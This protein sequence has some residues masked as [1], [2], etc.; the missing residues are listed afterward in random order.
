MLGIPRQ[1]NAKADLQDQKLR[2]EKLSDIIVSLI[3]LCSVF[4]LLW[5]PSDKETTVGQVPAF[6]EQLSSISDSASSSSSQRY[7]GRHC[8]P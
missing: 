2:L 6:T 8:L 1:Y 4:S 5:C 3:K 7:A